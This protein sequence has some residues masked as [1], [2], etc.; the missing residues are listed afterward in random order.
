MAMKLIPHRGF[1]FGIASSFLA[2]G[3]ALATSGPD[4]GASPFHPSPE[5]KKLIE[6]GWDCP[7]PFYIRQHVEEMEQRPFDGIVIQVKRSREP[8]HKTPTR[9]VLGWNVFSSTRFKPEEYQHAFEDLKAVKFKKFTENFIQVISMPGIDWFHPGWDAVT[10][11]VAVM[12]RLA[13]EGGCVGLM[14]DAEQY[15]DQRI[16]SYNSLPEARRSEMSREQYAA[17]VKERGGEFMRAINKEFSGIKILLLVGPT[18]AVTSKNRNYDL[19]PPFIEGMCLAADPGT[20]ITDGFEQSYGYIGKKSFQSARDTMLIETRK[21]F[22]NKEAFDRVMRAGFGL[23]L[24]NQSQSAS[25]K[26]WFADETERNYF[27]PYQWQTALHNA[28]S[29]SDRYVWSY[30]ER[31]DWWTNT[32]IGAAYEQATIAARKEPG[33]TPT[34]PSAAR[35]AAALKAASLSGYDDTATF[36]PLARTHE[37]VFGFPAKGWSFRMDPDDVGTQQEWFRVDLNAKDWSPIEIRKFWDEF[38]WN[39]VG[40]GWY[41][42]TFVAPGL[43]AGRRI[44]LVVGAA[45]EGAAV[46]LNGEKVG[47]FDQG[48]SGWDKRFSVDITGKLRAGKE[49]SIAIRVSNNEGIGGLWKSIKIMAVRTTPASADSDPGPDPSGGSPPTASVPPETDLVGYWSFDEGDAASAGEALHVGKNVGATPVEGRIGK[50]LHFVPGAYVECAK[51]PP[52]TRRFTFM[53][54]AKLDASSETVPRYPTILLYGVDGNSAYSICVSPADRQLTFASTA[55]QNRAWQNVRTDKNALELGK[56][57][58]AAVT[59]DTDEKVMK[60][61]LN[62]ALAASAPY[63]KPVFG[64]YP[65]WAWPLYFGVPPAWKHGNGSFCGALDEVKIYQR[66]LS[67]AE[68]QKEFESAGKREN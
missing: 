23:W 22:E 56:W 35:A 16:W 45:D 46:W 52:M 21:L 42:T 55:Q 53:F 68:I 25:R 15:G 37:T 43:P 14:F 51:V 32:T 59:Y 10:S 39:C 9:D 40:Y 18:Y 4:P 26:G 7:T 5:G 34:K 66:A 20:E 28:L 65:K 54:W 19:L 3:L 48:T 63:D 24:D 64:G 2:T 33:Q 61:Y 30:S 50:A 67:A 60:M 44:E 57:F 62:G 36:G 11:N 49:N 27:Q 47:E 8:Q 13:K 1:A 17:K 29:Y 58:Q 12:A 6:Y 31:L 38:G 41:R